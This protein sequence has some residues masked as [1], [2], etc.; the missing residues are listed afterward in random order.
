MDKQQV[1]FWLK[2]LMDLIESDRVHVDQI[3]GL[4]ADEVIALAEA[5]ANKAVDGADKLKRG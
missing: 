1:L 4:T 3:K 5:E 2:S